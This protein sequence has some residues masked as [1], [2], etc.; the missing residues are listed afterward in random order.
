MGV[1][2]HY[3]KRLEEAARYYKTAIRSDSSLAGVHANP[4]A[5]CLEKGM[6]DEAFFQGEKGA[7]Y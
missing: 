4:G 6:L 1:L 5:V 2:L 3:Q 7:Y